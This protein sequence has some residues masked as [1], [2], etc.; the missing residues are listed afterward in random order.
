MYSHF[1]EH[2]NI[3]AELAAMDVH[4]LQHGDHIPAIKYCY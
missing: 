3:M 4:V 1:W 2:C